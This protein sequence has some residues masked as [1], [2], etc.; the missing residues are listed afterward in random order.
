MGKVTE[1]QI[2]WFTQGHTAWKFD[3]ILGLNS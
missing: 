2:D 3:L 1:A